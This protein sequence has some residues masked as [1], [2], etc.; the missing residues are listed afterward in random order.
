MSNLSVSDTIPH[1][2]FNQI[3]WEMLPTDWALHLAS[4]IA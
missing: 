1:V 4:V 3:M 2:S